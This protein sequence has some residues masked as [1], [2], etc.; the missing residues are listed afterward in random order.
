MMDGMCV[1]GAMNDVMLYV[2]MT[3]MASHLQGGVPACEIG[4]R[5][6]YSG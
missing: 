3:V 6:L 2:M 4:V 5:T 1:V